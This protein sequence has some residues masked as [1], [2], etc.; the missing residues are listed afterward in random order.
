MDMQLT[1]TSITL[2]PHMCMVCSN[3]WLFTIVLYLGVGLLAVLLMFVLKLTLHL[4]TIGGLIFYVNIFAVTYLVPTQT[5]TEPVFL[6]N[7]DQSFPSCFFNRMTMSIKMGL[8]Y[9]YAFYLWLIVA[10]VL[11]ITRC[12][13]RATRVLMQSSMQVLIT[14]IHLSLS[15]MLITYIEVFSSST[16]I[17]EE[18]ESLVWLADGNVQ[19]GNTIGHIVL[20]CGATL[21][22]A[23]VIIPYLVLATL[24]SFGLRY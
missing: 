1:F 22:A 19:F 8:Q 4:G 24:G 5:F 2:G 17:T 20:L 23:V 21:V 13:F 10:V 3:Y 18:R 14:L 11:L 16:I 15:R 6:L 7:L 12:S 9:T